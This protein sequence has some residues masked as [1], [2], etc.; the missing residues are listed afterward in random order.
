VN[1]GWKLFTIG[2][3]VV[4]GGTVMDAA[5]RIL[6]SVMQKGT[7]GRMGNHFTVQKGSC[8]HT[9]PKS[10]TSWTPS[11]QHVK[12]SSGIMHTTTRDI[13]GAIGQEIRKHELRENFIC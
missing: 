4:K 11:L 9:T 3:G 1:Q 8:L 6:P 12:H 13:P 10:K 2:F 5:A 7:K